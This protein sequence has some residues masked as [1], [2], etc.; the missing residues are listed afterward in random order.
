[1]VRALGFTPISKQFDWV[2]T[3]LLR[4]DITVSRLA[5]ILGQVRITEKRPASFWLREFEE[6]RVRLNGFFMDR[7]EIERRGSTR[8]SDL[9]RAAPGLSIIPV[10][11]RYVVTSARAAPRLAGEECN[12]SYYLDGQPMALDVLA[13]IDLAISV[14]EIEAIEVYT[15]GSRVP[16]RFN[17][18]NGRCGVIALWTLAPSAH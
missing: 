17:Q 16:P 9:L 1:L 12:I 8:L 7:T 2:P 5:T 4:L 14:N 13:G 6:R 11:G 3:D 15:G 10:D 18:S